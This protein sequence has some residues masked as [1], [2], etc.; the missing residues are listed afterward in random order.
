[1]RKNFTLRGGVSNV[2]GRDPPLVSQSA[3][4]FGNGNTF[5]QAYDALGRNFFVNE[6]AKF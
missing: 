1:V 5:P 3:P 4:P 6:Q 2:F